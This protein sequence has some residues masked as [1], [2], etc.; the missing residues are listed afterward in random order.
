MLLRLPSLPSL[1]ECVCV[2]CVVE[3]FECSW[4]A[5][6]TLRILQHDA[7]VLVV[8]LTHT[9]THVSKINR[10]VY[11]IVYESTRVQLVFFESV[12]VRTVHIISLYRIIAHRK[13]IHAQ[14]QQNNKYASETVCEKTHTCTHQS[15][16]VCELIASECAH[17]HKRS[18]SNADNIR[19]RLLAQLCLAGND[20]DPKRPL[21]HSAYS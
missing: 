19:T 5:G 16:C 2:C 13:N 12:N 14:Q 6:R 7:C 8:V 9:H 11:I 21:I 10:H 3:L 20:L 18:C 1:R 4:R 15:Q 17:T